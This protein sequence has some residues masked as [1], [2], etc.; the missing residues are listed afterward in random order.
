MNDRRNSTAEER[1]ANELA[2]NMAAAGERAEYDAAAKRLVAQKP[3]LA[4]IL[5]SAL[6]EYAN[7][8]VERIAEEYIGVPQVGTAAVHQDHPDAAEPG[9]MD[10]SFR[11][12]GMPNEETSIREGS[13]FFDIRFTARVP[14]DD[15]LMEIIVNVEVQRKDKPGYPI[16]KRGIYYGSRLI[17]AQRGTVFKDQEYG[18]IK[19]VVSI[20]L[21]SG[22]DRKRSDTINE[23]VITEINRRGEYRERREDYDLMR[24]VVM[25]LGIKGEES[26]DAAIRLLSRLFS[27][28]RDDENKREVLSKEFKI[29]VTEEIDREV[30]EMC[31]LSAGIYDKGRQDG[32]AEGKAEGRAEGRAEGIARGMQLMAFGMVRKG[33]MSILEGAQEIGMEPSL[34][35]EEYRE[36]ILTAGA[37]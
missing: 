32:I 10:G 25:R 30:T 27:T 15:S 16:T 6:E 8:P 4:Y 35:E 18:K 1:M 36:Y 20:W 22:T 14:K 11:I 28:E 23:Y 17:S 21:C 2:Q 37:D 34:F 13:V 29:E 3:I 33:R 19:K 12:T 7:V 26:G 24:V 31:N 5:K 9:K